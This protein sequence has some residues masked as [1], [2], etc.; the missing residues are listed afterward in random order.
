MSKDVRLF[1][2]I[3]SD[4][5]KQNSEIPTILIPGGPGCDASVFMDHVPLLIK[6]GPVILFDP[7]GTGKSDFSSR[8]IDSDVEDLEYI[9]NH[10]GYKQW[11]ILGRSYGG[12]VA[13][14]YGIRY[15]NTLNKLVLDVTTPDNT[16]Y[17][18]ALR[19]LDKRGS[20]KQIEC[21][22]CILN[23]TI[24]NEEH[25]K[26]IFE[27]MRPLYSIYGKQHNKALEKGC[28]FDYTISNNGFKTYLKTINFTSELHRIT[29]PTLVLGGK[30]DWI[31]DPSLSY[32]I[33]ESLPC[34]QL[35]IMPGSHSLFND[36]PKLY[37]TT[38]NDF[39]KNLF[40][41]ENDH[42]KKMVA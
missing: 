5:K 33:F 42:R 23:G 38:V 34:A 7:R 19:N 28:P 40:P 4:S 39:F 22:K 13:Q 15:P 25:A 8:N 11:N 37:K 20:K 36:C 32:K 6:H 29:A 41:G 26:E 2:R 12:V 18:L 16:F 14:G 30:F 10:L 35:I 24:K 9:R 3:I 21:G 31:C 17:R 1:T 27:T